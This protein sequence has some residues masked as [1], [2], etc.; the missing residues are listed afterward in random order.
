MGFLN[1]LGFTDYAWNVF[2]CIGDYLHVAATFVLLSNLVR[3]QSCAGVSRSTQILY[4]TVF[5][6]RYLDL[7]DHAQIPYLVFFKLLFIAS[8]A[9]VLVIF[10]HLDKTYE[11]TK[12]TC[13]VTVILAPCAIAALMLTSRYS[14]LEVFWTFSEFVEGF[15]M[16]PQYI[17]CYRDKDRKDVGVSLYILCM[18]CYR[19]F[20]ILN[21]IY[22]K[23]E[24]PYY[25]DLSSWLGGI[26]E[27]LFFVDFLSYRFAGRS[28]LRTMVLSV[29]TKIN[30][31]S[32]A[33]ELKVVGSSSRGMNEDTGDHGYASLPS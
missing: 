19:V 29:D 25:R 31:M 5:V 15:A 12:D 6:T 20:Y 17:F 22:K 10:Y 4:F 21:W 7:L 1:P 14:I 8:S 9:I 32:E 18:G 27:M 24:N 2:R 26:I 16:V 11:R 23:I 13:G 28:M 3:N 33:M 30:E